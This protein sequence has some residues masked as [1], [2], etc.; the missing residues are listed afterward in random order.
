MV[1]PGSASGGASSVL[2]PGQGRVLLEGPSL[3]P[4]GVVYLDRLSADLHNVPMHQL[5]ATAGLHHTVDL[6][7]PPLDQEL[8]IPAT[9]R[10][11]TELQKLVQPQRVGI[12]L[13]R[14]IVGRH[15]ASPIA[16]QTAR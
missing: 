4:F 6:H 2:D 10:Q 3:T 5:P 15:K 12:I 7:L 16:H 1:P 8:G 9:F 13:R 14:R 11:R